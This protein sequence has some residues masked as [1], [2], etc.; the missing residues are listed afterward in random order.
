MNIIPKLKTFLV[1]GLAGVAVFVV[2]TNQTLLTNVFAQTSFTPTVAYQASGSSDQ[3][4]MTIWVHPTSPGDSLLI[5]SDK[6]SN[7]VFVYDIDGGAALQTVTD[8]GQPGNIDIRYNINLNGQNVDIVGFNDRGGS[9]IRLF[10]VDPSTRTLVRVDNGQIRTVSPNYGFALYKSPVSGKLY[11]FVSQDNGRAIEQYELTPSGAQ[12]GG[13]RVRNWTT[14]AGSQTEG[15]V[16]DDEKRLIYTTQE[17]QGVY[18]QGA[19]PGDSAPGPIVLPAG[20]NGLN[21]DLEGTTLYKTGNGNGYLIVSAQ[22]SSSFIVFD[23]NAGSTGQHAHRGSFKVANTSSTDGIDVINSNLGGSYPQGGFFAH[24]GGAAIR[25]VPW[26]TIASSLGLTIDISWNPRGGTSP[27]VPPGTSTPTRPPSATNSPSP[28]RAPNATNTPTTAS[29]NRT[30]RLFIDGT[31]RSQHTS[32]SP[33]QVSN[34]SAG[35]HTISL[36]L[37]EGN[38]FI[39]VQDSVTVTVSSGGGSTSTPTRPP[40]STSVPTVPPV[41]GDFPC[42]KYP[43]ASP[44]CMNVSYQSW[45]DNVPATAETMSVNY[46]PRLLHQHYDC[47]IPAA[48][49]N[50]Q[51]L[52]RGMKFVCGFVKYNSIVPSLSSNK[53]WYRTQNV[54]DTYEQFTLN[55]PP[56]Q[57]TKYEGKECK[58]ENI[59]TVRD[60]D[61]NES[62]EI[63][64]TPNA[65]FVGMGGQR[66][67]LSTNWQTEIGYRSTSELT[68]RYWIGEC[69]EYQRTIIKQSDKFMQGNEAI[70]TVRG[71]IQVPFETNGGCGSQHKTFVF[72]DPAQHVR[73]AGA[74]TGT[75]L[76]ET[77]GQFNG[78][79]SW[80][81]TRT[82][83]GVHNVLFINLEGTGEYV[84][85]SGVALRFNVQN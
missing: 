54:G 16:A 66:H 18:K 47:A 56:C 22:G 24:S 50:G 6:A 70:A 35:Q 83:N 2:Y 30:I 79:L 68:A 64:S 77:N 3:D 84:S 5:G 45:F 12:I 33:I 17:G 57:S 44:G 69:G 42:G 38:T 31:E 40:N 53:G 73:V 52:R 23:R 27:T 15:M 60:S 72:L 19:E 21:A 67:Y 65:E 43:N 26:N 49:A 36:R 76:M 81:T 37:Y 9:I 7:R 63:R 85:A 74:Q 82:S 55:L 46:T 48:R 11:G 71:T 51:Y 34:L 13:T 29:A 14:G 28:T 1:L 62:T 75:T 20:Q 61:M 8:V 41:S 59:H 4:D 80:D 78:N 32:T 39:G 58:T 25:G 10:R